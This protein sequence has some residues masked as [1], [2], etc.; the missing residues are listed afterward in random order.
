MNVQTGGRPVN[1]LLVEDN[2]RDVCLVQ[3]ALSK[4]EGVLYELECV[5]LLSTG[6]ERLAT[7]GIDLV[8]L[9]LTLPDSRG[10][11]TFA[12]TYS[13]VPQVPIIVLT[14]LG[15]EDLAVK[16]LGEG[17]QDYLIKEQVDT[18][19]LTRAI[20]YAIERKRAD[21]ENL[22]LATAINEARE[23]II[24]T[25]AEGTIQ[26][27][28]PAFQDMSGYVRKDVIGQ[29]IRIL[30]SG[31]DN[32]MFLQAMWDAIGS[33]EVWTC[34]FI[35]KKKDGTLYE[36]EARISPVRDNSGTII[37]YV[38]VQRD[39]THEIQLEKLL[40]QAQKMEAIGTLA[41]GIA[42]D[43]NNLLMA[44]QGNVSLMLYD[45]DSTHPHYKFLTNIIKEVRSGAELTARFLGY[46]RKGKYQ[47]KPVNL[48]KLVIETSESI[49]RARKE[50]SIHRELAADLFAIEADYGQIQQVLLNLFVN[51]AD[52]MPVGGDLI[53]KTANVTHQDMENKLYDPKPGNYVQLTVTDTGRGMDKETRKRIFEPFFTTKEMGLGTGLGLASTYGIIK[54][55]SGYIDVDS[56]QGRG[57]T[58]TIYLPATEK[59]V[60]EAVLPTE[61]IVKG[62]G[63]ILLV[64]DEERI[65]EVGVKMLERLG[66]TVLEA[67]NGR[68]AVEIYK[69]NKDKIDLVILDMIM[70]RMGGGEAYDRMKEI[71]PNLKVLLSSGYSID[72]QAQEI[73]KRGCDGFIQKVFGMQELSQRIREVLDKK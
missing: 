26:Y 33:G 48:N 3:D 63:T 55:H 40:R 43:F 37:N 13:Q 50:I 38:S 70:P 65:L 27:V 22:R 30:G 54:D 1:I 64:E 12:K 8:L 51:A 24:I 29:N 35:T 72:S 5:N 4:A 39:V 28:N 66:Y 19:L 10:L 45:I 61:Q 59:K 20:R 34:Q 21:E 9:D 68:E 56:E 53:L 71:N 73:L 25:D 15:D 58:F 42:H 67:R 46:A 2:H 47:V 57:S 14:S 31:K 41:G 16:S 32:D 11:D 6:L 18:N 69:E 36:A 52:A 17:A 23:S 49:G 60:E 44:I 62:T 7:G